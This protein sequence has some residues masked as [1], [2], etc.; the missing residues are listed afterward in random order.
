MTEQWKNALTQLRQRI[1]AL[2]GDY[3]AGLKDRRARKFD[4]AVR[5]PFDSADAQ[6]RYLVPLY[7][8]FLAVSQLQTPVMQG[9]PPRSAS[10]YMTKF[11]S[12]RLVLNEVAAYQSQESIVRL[13]GGGTGELL[14]L[15]PDRDWELHTVSEIYEAVK[16]AR[17]NRQAFDRQQR[18]KAEA[19]RLAFLQSLTHEQ[20]DLLKEAFDAAKAIGTHA[21]SF[22]ERDVTI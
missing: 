22:H 4:P 9:L 19:A 17:A 13:L 21:V 8:A 16:T 7:R 18:S 12:L 2:R 10:L 11:S 1:R 15:N 3:H 5:D 14:I 20:T 6:L